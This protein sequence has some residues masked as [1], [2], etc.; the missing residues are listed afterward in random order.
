MCGMPRQVDKL[1]CVKLWFARTETV[2]LRLRFQPNEEEPFMR[3]K[4]VILAFALSAAAVSLFAPTKAYSLRCLY[5]YTL[6]GED[7]ICCHWNGYCPP[8]P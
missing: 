7:I 6:C 1:F 5:G 4:L 3:K 2:S 8:C